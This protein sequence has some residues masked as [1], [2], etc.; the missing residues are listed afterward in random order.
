ML[1]L[2][3]CTC[4]QGYECVGNCGVCRMNNKALFN[5]NTLYPARYYTYLTIRTDSE[6]QRHLKMTRTRWS[7]EYGVNIACFPNACRCEKS[8]KP[9]PKPKTP[10]SRRHF[11]PWWLILLGGIIAVLVAVGVCQVVPR[12]LQRRRRR[13]ALAAMCVSMEHHSRQGSD[14]CTIGKQG[15]L[16]V[17]I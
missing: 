16:P 8:T 7:E 14:H 13:R 4:N 6:P 12:L 3:S 17:Q 9:D 15:N 11:L 1:C 10:A 5:P 2:H